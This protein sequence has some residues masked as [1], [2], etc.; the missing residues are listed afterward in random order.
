MGVDSPKSTLEAEDHVLKAEHFDPIKS[1]LIRDDLHMREHLRSKGHLLT[2]A[3]K[4]IRPTRAKHLLQWHAENQ[5]KNILFVEEKIFTIKK[6]YN[7]QYNKIYAQLSLEVRSE[8]ARGHQPSYFMVW[9]GVSHQGVTP[10]HFCKKGVQTGARVYQE[11]MLQGVVKPLNTT[12]FSGQKW[13]FQQDSAPAHK[14]KITQEWP[15]RKVPAF[16]ST[17]DW[18]SGRPDLN[19]RDYQLWAVLED[20]ACRKRHN[21]LDSLKRSLVKAAAEIALE[22]VHAVIAEWPEHLKA[23]IGA[24]GGHFD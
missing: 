17:E 6:Q 3:M 1:C 15:W 13:V 4:E 10:L 5:H 11:D 12:V 8:G 16:I 18:P 24:E 23:C 9:W 7:N 22:T 14:A 21:N 20:M 19:P 2:P